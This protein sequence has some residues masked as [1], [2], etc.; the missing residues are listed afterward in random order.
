MAAKTLKIHVS[1]TLQHVALPLDD[2]K[3]DFN[4]VDV[5]I[6][7]DQRQMPTLCK[8]WRRDSACFKLS[9]AKALVVA[10]DQK[11]FPT[12]IRLE[13]EGRLAGSNVQIHSPSKPIGCLMGGTINNV[14]LVSIDGC[15]PQAFAESSG[16]ITVPANV[17]AA[18]EELAEQAKL[19]SEEAMR[20]RAPIEERQRYENPKAAYERAMYIVNRQR[21]LTSP[22]LTDQDIYE[23]RD[24]LNLLK[25]TIEQGGSLD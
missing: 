24:A 18:A 14:K 3:Y 11:H 10:D 25:E 15:D 16:S 17:A 4:L 9:E 20:A 5:T 2:N 19:E 21:K 1:G 13:L 23:M 12:G 8:S 6:S 7:H 22:K